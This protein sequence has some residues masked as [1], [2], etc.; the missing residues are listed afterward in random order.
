MCIAG[1]FNNSWST[2]WL[3]FQFEFLNERLLGVGHSVPPF[4]EVG[5]LISFNTN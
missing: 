1:Y 5:K 2:D 3:Q 4:R